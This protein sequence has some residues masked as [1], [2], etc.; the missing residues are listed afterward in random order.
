MRGLVPWLRVAKTWRAPAGPGASPR[1]AVPVNVG[2]R[3]Q[4]FDVHDFVDDDLV[5]GM[6]QLIATHWRSTSV[7]MAADCRG[8]NS[9]AIRSYWVDRRVFGIWLWQH[10][11]R[12]R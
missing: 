5:E 3:N 9:G 12:A 8:S 11:K 7:C 2:G 6:C 4:L 1:G 10:G